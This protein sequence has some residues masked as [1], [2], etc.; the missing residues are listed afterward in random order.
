[1]IARSPS[2]RQGRDRKHLEAR[3]QAQENCARCKT[4]RLIRA[5]SR[6]ERVIFKSRAVASSL[7]P[8]SVTL[9]A[10]RISS[11]QIGQMRCRLCQFHLTKVSRLPC[12]LHQAWL[13]FR[14]RYHSSMIQTKF[15][16]IKSCLPTQTES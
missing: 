16:P 3:C 10:L 2:Q 8:K 6:I 7:V 11:I 13:K 9:S 15:M 1:M 4:N 14:V 5:V 12:R